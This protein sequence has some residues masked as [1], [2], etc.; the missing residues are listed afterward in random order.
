MQYSVWPKSKTADADPAAAAA[1]AGRLPAR[2]DGGVAGAGG[3]RVRHPSA[4]AD[5]PA[6]DADREQRVL[7]PERLS[8]RVSVATLRL[9][10]QRFN[11]PAQMEF[12]KRLSYNP[13][14]C[15]PEHRP[16]GNQSRARRRMY[17]ELSKLRH[18]DER[19]AALRADRGRGVRV[20]PMTP[21]ST[22]MVLA[23]IDPG[24]E[25]EL[26]RLLDVDE[27]CAWTRQARQRARPVRAVRWP[28]RRA[29]SHRGRPDAGRQP[30][31]RHPGAG[32]SAR[33]GVS[34]RRGRRCRRLSRRCERPRGRRA[35]RDLLVLRRLHRR[36]GP[37][38]SGCARTRC[39]RRP[40]YVNWRGRTVRQV[41]EEAALRDAL[42]AACESIDA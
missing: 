42:R 3:R 13:W 18:T 35:A 39:R 22:F 40:A 6:S 15:I 17:Y 37:S 30:R 20:A 38:R 27:R 5:R 25:A 32:L 12:A 33:P 34:R 1:S 9:P 10:R 31:L 4:A 23:P 8:P 19:R 7:W 29:V 16:L 28:A 24:R 14:H 41:R 21:Q 11:S 2:R 36:D 26:R